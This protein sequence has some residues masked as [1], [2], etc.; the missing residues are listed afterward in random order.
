[1]AHRKLRT[2]CIENGC[3]AVNSINTIENS[4]IALKPEFACLVY[5]QP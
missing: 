1:M 2:R 3:G 5:Y 4:K